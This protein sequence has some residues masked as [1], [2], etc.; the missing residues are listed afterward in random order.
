[1]ALVPINE[2]GE[3]IGSTYLAVDRVQAGIGDRVITLTEG[4]GARQIFGLPKTADLP[5]R[6]LI[7]GIVDAVEHKP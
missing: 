3:T 5:I 6:T 2:K 7:V 1:M 4:T